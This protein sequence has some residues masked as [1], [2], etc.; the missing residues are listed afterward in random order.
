[1]EKKEN[2]EE[3]LSRRDFL[4]K[5]AKLLPVIAGASLGMGLLSS[6]DKDDDDDDDDSGSSSGCSG[7]GHGCSGNCTSCSGSC[8]GG[9]SVG[10]TSMS[11]YA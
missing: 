2:N 10:C 6:C 3:V 8:K 7:C 1:M 9:C 5:T 11:Y 4:K